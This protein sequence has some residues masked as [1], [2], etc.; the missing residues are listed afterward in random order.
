[1]F[2]KIV[3]FIFIIFLFSFCQSKRDAIVETYEVKKSTFVSSV[4]ETGEL[5]AVNSEAISA[6]SIS[7]AWSAR[8]TSTACA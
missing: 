7:W 1:M 4:T 6:P 2:H 8:P 3:K 5:A